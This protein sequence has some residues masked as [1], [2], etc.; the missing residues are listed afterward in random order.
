MAGRPPKDTKPKTIFLNTTVIQPALGI[1]DPG[2]A[3]LLAQQMAETLWLPPGAN[4]QAKVDAAISALAGIAP[5]GTLEGM[6]AVQMV[7]THSAAMECLRRAAIPDQSFQACDMNLKHATKLLTV[8]ARQLEALDRHRGKGQ[9]KITVEHV[10]V[11]AGGQA[12]VGAIE[13][14]QIGKDRQALAAPDETAGNA[15]PL[16]EQNRTPTGD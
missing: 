11:N 12:I 2:L 9:Q 7:A 3:A 1:S 8:Y 13:G 5:K 16:I 10:T 14:A 15:I 6:L 4:V